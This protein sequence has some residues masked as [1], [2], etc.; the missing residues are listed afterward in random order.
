METK[1]EK[2]YTKEPLQGEELK[3]LN[4]QRLDIILQIRKLC[5][6]IC[7]IS[8]KANLY[9]LKTAGEALVDEQS[10]KLSMFREALITKAMGD[11]TLPTRAIKELLSVSDEK[12]L[13]TIEESGET[14]DD[15]LKLML[16]SMMMDILMKGMKPNV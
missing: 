10:K 5:T 7:K 3:I 2:D 16:E 6:E 14:L 12:L 13:Q 1:T 15:A 11:M 8:G 4:Q 9:F